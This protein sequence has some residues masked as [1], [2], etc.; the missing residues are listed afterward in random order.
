MGVDQMKDW[1]TKFHADGV[2]FHVAPPAQGAYFDNVR[3]FLHGKT[4]CGHI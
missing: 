2:Y 4:S 1:I 3:Y